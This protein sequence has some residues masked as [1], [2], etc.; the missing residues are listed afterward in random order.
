M[1]LPL[2]WTDS[3][4]AVLVNHLWQSTVVAGIAWLLVS[5][6][7][8]N[9][10]RVRF[11]I[12]F[13]ASAKFL[14]PFSLLTL[15]GEWM[16]SLVAVPVAGKP[17]AAAVMAKLVRPYSEAGAFA[18][19]VAPAAIHPV[20]WFPFVLPV[21]WGIGVLLVAARYARCWQRVH[22]ATRSAQPLELKANVPVLCTARS[23]EPGIFG[24]FRPVL[25][26][27]EG[28]LDRLSAGQL[29]AILAHEMCHVRRRDNLT[30]ALHQVVQALFWFH[31]ATW[32]I[33]T[34]LMEERERACDEAVVRAS[35]TAE[36]YAEG[37]LNVCRYYLESPACVAGVTGADLKQRIVRIMAGQRARNLS[38]SRK[39]VLAVLCATIL[40]LPVVAGLA[41]A[42]QE[43]AQPQNEDTPHLPQFDVVSVKPHKDEGM[44][45][46]MAF[47]F[48]PD[49]ITADGMPLDELLRNAF[50]LPSD[51]ILNEPE[52]TKSSRF[53]IQAK[54]A[55]EDA[56]KMKALSADQR[57][58][59][60]IPMFEDR[61]RLKFHHETKDMEVYTLEVAKGGPKLKEATPE[62][63]AASGPPPD[64]GKPGEPNRPR[65]GQMMMSVSPQG[66]TL[67]ATAATVPGLIRM[68]SNQIG[69]TIV[70]KTGLTGTYDYTLSFAPEDGAG[71]IMGPAREGPP[72]GGGQTQ[73]PVG[74]SVFTAI[75]EQLGLRLVPQ[76]QQVDVIVI[77]HIEQPSA[78]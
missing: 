12:W 25:L 56:P 30:F 19:G 61:F 29:R 63:L 65:K 18:G 24:I 36:V 5:A 60:L 28:I 13:A 10:A 48:S 17:E 6:L 21:I 72:D 76:K 16:R 7:R 23:M 47:M 54:V 41:W 71:P 75:Q 8:K 42:R 9:H 52:W 73:D 4:T 20:S 46:R 34:Q 38:L 70:D 14:L 37:I 58:T 2:F 27:P 68:L 11:W 49:G 22:L 33:G 39:L 53:D 55:P 40:G 59:M 45:M 69:S 67:Q 64:P 15:A 1:N 44:N 43:P 31:P 78:N 62:E 3:L 26:L 57:R 32:W 66:M 50:N 35:D 74:P 77:D 51:R